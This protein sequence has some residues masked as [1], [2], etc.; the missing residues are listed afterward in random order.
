[1]G[2]LL[3]PQIDTGT[4]FHVSE[5]NPQKFY[6]TRVYT[7]RVCRDVRFRFGYNLKMEGPECEKNE[8][9]LLSMCWP[10]KIHLRRNYC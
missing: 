9:K 2:P 1:M 3:I 10:Y 6:P 5:Q 7:S 8:E 4:I